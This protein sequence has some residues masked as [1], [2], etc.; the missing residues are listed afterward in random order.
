MNQFFCSLYY[1]AL[2]KWRM[3][4]IHEDKFKFIPWLCESLMKE[5]LLLPVPAHLLI[6][7]GKDDNDNRATD[8]RVRLTDRAF[9]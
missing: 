1:W 6:Q 8:A 3:K 5:K 9:E 4:E 7:E 2:W